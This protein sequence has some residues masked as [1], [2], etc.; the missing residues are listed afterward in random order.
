MA[1]KVQRKVWEQD[2][3]TSV[4]A[5]DGG[6]VLEHDIN[7]IV[8]LEPSGRKIQGQIM[9]PLPKQEKMRSNVQAILHPRSLYIQVNPLLLSR[10]FC[11]HS[12]FSASLV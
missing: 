9:P 10:L 3:G 8:R 7:K 11:I 4:M 12:Y 5:G 6:P 2:V 1:L